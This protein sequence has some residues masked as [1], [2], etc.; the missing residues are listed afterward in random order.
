ML[1]WLFTRGPANGALVIRR[2]MKRHWIQKW[3]VLAGTLALAGCSET[4]PPHA[5]KEAIQEICSTEYGIEKIDI[6]ITGRTI[7]VFLPIKKLFVMD[8]KEVLTQSGGKIEEMENLFQPAPEALDQVED[9]LFSISRVLL[10]TERKLDFY[11]LQ[12]TDVENTGL[13]LVLYGYVND[14]KRVRLWDISREEY[15][16]RILHELRLNRAVV[17]HRPVKS[18]FGTLEKSPSLKVVQEYFSVPLEPR[19]FESLFFFN[20]DT[21]KGPVR[22]HLGEFR[23]VSVSTTEILVYAPVIF[24]YDPAS[25]PPGNIRLP[26]GTPLEYIFVV[27]FASERAQIMRVIP[28]FVREEPGRLRRIRRLSGVN[29]AH[30]IDSWESEFALTEIHLGNY[31]AEQL[32]RRSQ[33]LLYSDERIQNT[34]ESVR[35]AF[36]YEKD[37]KEPT[38]N[39]FSLDLEVKPRTHTELRPGPSALDEDVV[40]LLNRVSREFVDLL[41]SYHFSDFQFLQLNLVSDPVARILVREELELFRQKK[42]DLRGLL[43]TGLAGF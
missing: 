30:D 35:V 21:L 24:D 3:A 26:A 9:V 7:G 42:I 17:W 27:S 28:L 38:G 31:L 5:I 33:N 15:R 18:F 8:L 12:A 20:P 23:S 41:R 34:F 19:M 11:V 4:Y 40:Y 13:Q 32:T 29:V 6:K 36:R 22:W 37:P 43:M 14:I 2:K 1:F 10:S 39:Y 16:K 25:V